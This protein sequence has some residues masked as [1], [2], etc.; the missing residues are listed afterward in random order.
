MEY[1]VSQQ[2]RGHRL[3]LVK[4]LIRRDLKVRYRGSFLGY[5]WSML[6]PLLMMTVMT[7]VFSHAMRVDLPNYPIYILSGLLAWNMFSQSINLGV[8]SFVD[9]AAL[10]KK[11]RIP[12]WIFSSATI[13]SAF[14]HACFAFV[15]YIVIALATGFSFSVGLLQLPLVML[16]FYLF[17]Q[18]VVLM[19]A[20]LNVFFRDVGHVVEPILQIV[21]YAS[22][23]LYPVSA[24]P[25]KYRVLLDFNPVSHYLRGFRSALYSFPILT[26]A[27]WSAM[28][29]ISAF[30]LFLGS[31]VYNRGRDRFLYYL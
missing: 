30:S 3:E 2:S 31:W 24:L 4:L 1:V 8:R 13:G 21:F 26:V 12:S 14:V 16:L 7:V 20:T 10:L 9:N 15:P 22:P 18:G 5:L 11:V 17:V 25:E 29:A 27:D 6:N 19:I 28:A 23:V